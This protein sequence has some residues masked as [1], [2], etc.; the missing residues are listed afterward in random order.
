MKLYAAG[1]DAIQLGA[2]IVDIAPV[3][4]FNEEDRKKYIP[5]PNPEA[6]SIKK[7]LSLI[8]RS[9]VWFLV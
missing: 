3:R 4:G 6:W 8:R 2:S 9:V 5:G 7:S 1:V